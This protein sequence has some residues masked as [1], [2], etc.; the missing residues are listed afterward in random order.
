M[1]PYALVFIS[2]VLV[3]CIPVFAPPAWMLMMLIMF[4]FDLSPGLVVFI[5]T[6]GT[7]TGR[8]I[9]VS[10]IVPWIGRRTIGHKKEAD[11]K[12]V[13]KKIS[14]NG[15][16]TFLFVFIYSVLPLSTTALFTAVSLAKVK[17][18]LIIPPFFLGNLIGDG[19]IIISGKYAIANF[20]DL[21]KGSFELK[22][23]LLMSFGLVVMIL[24][25]FIDW[26][27]LLE[28]KRVKFKWKFWK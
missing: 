14:D 8:L 24:F 1:L 13:G 26:R 21:Y 19:L 10:Y 6:A 23:I 16:S 11:L 18:I 25:L 27:G 7:V 12:F 20:S 28:N 3:D 5:G 9:F 15:V 4:K 22:N 17:R 2:S